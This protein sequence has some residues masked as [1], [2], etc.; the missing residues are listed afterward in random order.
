MADMSRSEAAIPA[1]PAIP[2]LVYVSDTEPGIRR[3]RRGR[4]FCYRLPDGRLLKDEEQLARIRALGLPPAYTDVWICLDPNGHL[5]A[6]GLDARGRKQ[7]RY[8]RDWA[9]WRSTRK[10]TDLAAFAEALPRIRRAVLRDLENPRDDAV[11]LLAALVALL[12]ATYLRVGNRSYTRENG[13]YGATTL[14][15]KHFRFGPDGIRLSFRAKGGKRVQRTLRHPRLQKI[16]ELIADLPGREF[17][18]W[19]DDEGVPHR[20]DSGR[21]NAYLSEIA[22]LDLSAKT[23]RTWGGSLAA[24]EQAYKALREE[25]TPT[26]RE[27]CAA[28]AEALCNTPTICRTSYVHPAVLALSEADPGQD[29]AWLEAGNVNSGLRANERRLASLLSGWSG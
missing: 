9:D 11:F 7:Y 1:A 4:G 21:L 24:F 19:R 22:G 27:M 5:Q 26:I 23:F 29:L 2:G 28:A 13:S 3:E 10:Y 12:D 8:H 18:S 17:F 20:I 6:T 14:L 15:K 25:R 16:L